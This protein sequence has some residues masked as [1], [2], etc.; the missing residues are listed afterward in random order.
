[1]V[2]N[3]RPHRWPACS[4]CCLIF[5]VAARNS[6]R[7]CCVLLQPTGYSRT[8]GRPWCWSI[9]GVGIRGISNI[10]GSSW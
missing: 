6:N 4:C 10:T 9:F 1:V 8:V 5:T 3:V 2:T 7:N